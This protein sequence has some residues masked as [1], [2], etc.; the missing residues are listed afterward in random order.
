MIGTRAR[1]TL[2]GGAAA[3]VTFA[4][5]ALGGCAQEAQELTVVQPAPPGITPVEVRLDAA[6][7]AALSIAA[8]NAAIQRAR[9]ART[10]AADP[11]VRAFANQ[12]LSESQTAAQLMQQQVQRLGITPEPEATARQ[13]QTNAARTVALM[14]AAQGL[15]VDR[16]YLNREIESDRWVIQTLGT[17]ITAAPSGD[18]RRTLTDLQALMTARLNKAERLRA[19][20]LSQTGG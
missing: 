5:I 13:V 15:D 19:S 18:A 7:V 17:A 9:V 8:N 2:A 16:I 4:A 12:V 20:V 6:N 14:R 1:K 10:R 3:A 11:R